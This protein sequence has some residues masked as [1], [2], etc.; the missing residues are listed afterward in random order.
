MGEASARNAST[1]DAAVISFLILLTLFT[2]DA[3]CSTLA[4]ANVTPFWSVSGKVRDS[5]GRPITNALITLR[6]LDGRTVAHALSGAQGTFELRVNYSG[7]YD[8]IVRKGGFKNAEWTEVLQ[9]RTKIA[10]DLVMESQQALTMPVTAARI[11]AQNGLSASG[12]NKYTLT[13]NDIA[14]LPQGEATSLNEV[15]LQMP[16]VARHAWRRRKPGLPAVQPI[17]LRTPYSRW[18]RRHASTFAPS[19]TS[20]KEIRR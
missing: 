10:L 8:L 3:T 17:P 20:Y 12:T 1:Q 16:G 7:V 2:I 14:N 19:H 13:S 18:S 4:A 5:L 9:D 6:A 11:R 15:M